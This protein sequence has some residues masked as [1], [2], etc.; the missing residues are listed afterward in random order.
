MR[1]MMGVLQTVGVLGLQK[2]QRIVD[3]IAKHGIFTT[4]C[5]Y[6][7]AGGIARRRSMRREYLGKG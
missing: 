5:Q 2:S 4:S 6:M 3:L 7:H 1:S